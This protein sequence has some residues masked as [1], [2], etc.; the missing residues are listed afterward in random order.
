MKVKKNSLTWKTWNRYELPFFQKKW[1]MPIASAN[2]MT[3]SLVTVLTHFSPMF[4]SYNPWKRRFKEV[5]LHKKWS[6]PLRISSVNRPK[7]SLME[8]FIFCAVYR[9]ERL[10]ILPV[11]LMNDEISQDV[12][13]EQ[14]YFVPEK[15]VK[16]WYLETL[17]DVSLL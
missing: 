7:K 11:S 10:M 12:K 6:F 14:L 3:K 9:K 15:Q 13:K 4:N 2:S 16:I 8:N 5:S 1:A 17:I